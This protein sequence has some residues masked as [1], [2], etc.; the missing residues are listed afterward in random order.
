MENW[1]TVATFTYPTEVA[2]IKSYLEAEGI[3]FNMK[4]ELAI[5]ADNFMSNAIGGVKLQVTSEDLERVKQI[6]IEFGFT[7][8]QEFV[9]SPFWTKFDEVTSKIPFVRMLKVEARFTVISAVSLLLLV[10]LIY[11]GN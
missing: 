1:I 8:D 3:E 6:V 10:S 7:P 11:F 2:L 4:D 9:P 5:Q